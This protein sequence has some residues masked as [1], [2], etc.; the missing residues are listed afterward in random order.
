MLFRRRVEEA[1]RRQLLQHMGNGTLGKWELVPCA[2]P[3]YQL[4]I[5]Q[6]K[7]VSVMYNAHTLES[8]GFSFVTM[9]SVEE[10]EAAV[11]VQCRRIDG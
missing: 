7:K 8:H 3:T 10:A 2:H 5:V 1:Q 4:I 11:V 6:V 9:K